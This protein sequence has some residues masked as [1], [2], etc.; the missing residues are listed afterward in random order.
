MLATAHFQENDLDGIR[1]IDSND[2]AISFGRDRE[3]AGSANSVEEERNRAQ[4]LA[5]TQEQQDGQQQDGRRL[6]GNPANC[7]ADNLQTT[8][9]KVVDHS[10]NR[11][12]R[13][14]ITTS[15][16]IGIINQCLRE[17]E[18]QGSCKVRIICTVSSEP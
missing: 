8:F 1:P 12:D 7:R 16:D 10:Y 6:G 3:N 15:R 4:Q 14:Q 11:G 2:F 17:C 13:Q 9:E 5:Q 18:D